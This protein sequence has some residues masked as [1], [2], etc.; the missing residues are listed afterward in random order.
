MVQFFQ[1]LPDQGQEQASAIAKG[2]GGGVSQGIKT[3]LSKQL[4]GFLQQKKE[5][6]K[7]ATSVN[8]IAKRYG[9]DA[10]DATKLGELQNRTS[11]LIREG[12]LSAQ[13]AT[14]L[15]FL[16]NDEKANQEAQQEETRKA[17]NPGVFDK[18]KDAF[19]FRSNED[20]GK[21]LKTLGQKTAY[22]FVG[23]YD[24]LREFTSPNAAVEQDLARQGYTREEIAQSR[25]EI[26]KN[27]PGFLQG[28]PPEPV[29]PKYLEATGG[30]GPGEN[31]LERA[32]Q[33]YLIGGIPGVISGLFGEGA[34]YFDAPES[35]KLGAEVAGFV[36]GLF[37]HK[38]KGAAQKAGRKILANAEKKA[39][40][41]GKQI[42]EVI[43]D[44]VKESGADLSKVSEGN[45]AEINK[46]NRK[47][48]AEA[49]GAEKV[50]ATEKTVFNP[51]QAIKEREA[52]GKKLE[53]SPFRENFEIENKKAKAEAA[54]SPETRAKEAEVSKRVQPKI[55]ELE[56]QIDS[57]RKELANLENY[58]KKYTG[59]GKERLELN[60]SSKRKAIDK[61]ME[62]LKDLKY[63]LKNGKLRHT[64][65]QLE[66][67]AQNAA[68]KIVEHVR[69]PTPENAKAFE[70]QLT[71]DQR[72]LDR[73]E[74]TRKRGEFDKE[75][76]ADEHIRIM[77]KYQ[78]A[79]DAM[80]VQ[81]KDEIKSLK[82]VRD[83]ESLKKIA[84]NREAIKRL[85]QRQLRHKA[86]IT[87]QKEKIIALKS[88]EGP[89]GALY[90]NQIKRT[91]GDLAEFQKDFAKF[92]KGAETKAEIG[93]EHK[94]Q[95]AIKETGKEFEKATKVGE[96]V[97]K[98]PTQENI[99]KAAE[100]TGIPEEK[101]KQ[102]TEKLGDIMKENS[103][104]IASGKANES[105]IQQ[106]IKKIKPH[107]QLQP[108]LRAFGLH[109]GIGSLLGVVENE[110]GYHIPRYALY[111]T[112]TYV[113][114]K[115]GLPRRNI[116]RQ[117]GFGSGRELVNYIY[118]RAEGEKLKSLRK[119]PVEYSRQVQN[120]KRRY[121]A[122]RVNKIIEYSK[123]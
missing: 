60:I 2:F 95:K 87:N 93:T 31:V 84:D 11:Q 111:P 108:N 79:Y 114:E 74:A 51:E 105:T 34:E 72:F 1:Q 54:K 123:N 83:A 36:A 40:S 101:I 69:N 4:S 20:V 37:T 97:G 117:L 116:G 44:A 39:A 59:Q 80:V 7:A 88:I 82:G 9:K 118:K 98:N 56:K 62:Y 78:K 115:F 42:G 45:A 6:G 67:E 19:K 90:K 16:E 15:A 22:P 57:N 8:L 47:I 18:L 63:E 38:I 27:L 110:T 12:N 96:D 99:A 106:T 41:S 86:N 92:K 58:A 65:A 112:S 120:L 23:L 10:F 75:F 61:Q 17:E 76:R 73:A 5:L 24:T 109:F 55:A 21:S 66:I 85:E 68:K 103:E 29:T 100:E 94:G 77:E 89:S 102:N 53:T 43:A 25:Q 49:P 50:K 113:G 14:L 13:D 70:A 30:V 33:N 3:G 119:N 81:L 71:Q 122:Q 121:S 104:K 52:H 32:G 35:V 64:E 28:G 91:Q 46:L 48:T 107:L 26:Q